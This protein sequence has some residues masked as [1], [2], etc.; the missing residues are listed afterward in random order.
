MLRFII[1]FILIAL[2]GTVIQAIDITS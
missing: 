1:F 2:T